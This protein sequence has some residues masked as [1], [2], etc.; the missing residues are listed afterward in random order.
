VD[1]LVQKKSGSGGAGGAGGSGMG[2]SGMGG[3][4]MGGSGMGGSDNTGGSAPSTPSDEGCGCSV[5]GAESRPESAGALAT[6]VAMAGALV[7]RRRRST[8]R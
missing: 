4:G 2:G 8:G 3:S 7:R 5:P 1:V 6:L